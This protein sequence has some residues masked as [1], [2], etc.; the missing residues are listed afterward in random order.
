MAGIRIPPSE[1]IRKEIREMVRGMREAG[2]FAGNPIEKLMEKAKLLIVEELLEKEVEEFLE[3]PYYQRKKQGSEMKG[4]RNGYEPRKL[5]TAEGV[6]TVE[7]PQVRDSQEPFRSEI[8]KFFKNNTEVLEKLS[9]EMYVRGLSTRDIEEA[10]YTATGDRL[11]S[12]SSVSRVSEILWKEYEWFI[13]RDLSEFDIV[14]L[15]VDAV[16][17]SIRP[18]IRTNEAILVAYGIDSE[19]RKVLLHMDVGNKESYDF[20]RD[21]LR[22]MRKRGLKTPLTVT[23]DRAPGLIKAIEEIFP[24]CLRIRCWVHRM[25]NLSNKLPPELWQMIKPEVVAIRDALTYEEGKE[26]LSNVPGGTD[27]RGGEE[28]NQGYSEEPERAETD[29]TTQDTVES[30]RGKVF[31]Y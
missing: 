14:Y 6:L 3:R 21:F 12:K 11:L 15:I 25:R 20:C 5:K 26:R 27:V 17:E 24:R 31:W 19:G 10:L 22:N 7:V 9:T 23:S 2:K 29:R 4:Y 28:K 1:K 18:Y 16:Y 8:Q 13:S 30:R